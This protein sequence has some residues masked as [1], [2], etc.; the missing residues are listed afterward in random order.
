[1]LAFFISVPSEIRSLCLSERS[2]ARYNL[3]V[4]ANSTGVTG[5]EEFWR[6]AF[7]YRSHETTEL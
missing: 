6:Q 1:V 5:P 3:G 7:T 4:P 2:K